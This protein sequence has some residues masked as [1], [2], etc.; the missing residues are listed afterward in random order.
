MNSNCELW[1]AK[2][3]CN[4]NRQF[5]SI[6]CRKSCNLCGDIRRETTKRLA[7]TTTLDLSVFESLCKDEFTHCPVFALRGDCML[8]F[9]S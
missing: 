1:S 6:E 5:M 7:T 3:E 8:N 4:R 2:G 9:F